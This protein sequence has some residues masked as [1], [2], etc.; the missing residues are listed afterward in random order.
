MNLTDDPGNDPQHFVF[1]LKVRDCYTERNALCDLAQR[2]VG[3][4]RPCAVT[5]KLGSGGCV[6]LATLEPSHD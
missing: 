4:A 2:P 5:A 3:S 6:V 1:E